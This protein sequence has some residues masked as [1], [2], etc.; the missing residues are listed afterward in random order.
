[1]KC[2]SECP[3]F[4]ADHMPDDWPFGPVYICRHECKLGGSPIENK[5][6]CDI[7]EKRI[8]KIKEL[9]K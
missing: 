8:T 6:E 7:S 3:L 5:G 4:V 1:M 9:I 2:N